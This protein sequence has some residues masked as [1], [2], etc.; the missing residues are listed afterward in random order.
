VPRKISGPQLLKEN[1]LKDI[2]FFKDISA[3]VAYIHD[4]SLNGTITYDALDDG[5]PNSRSEVEI[6]CSGNRNNFGIVLHSNGHLYA[7][8]NGPN[9]GYGMYMAGATCDKN[10]YDRV[11][12]YICVDQMCMYA[13]ISV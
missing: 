6:Y 13:P 4:S 8:D 10:C 2:I 1:Y 5:A 7:T 9:F 3:A 11:I 12:A